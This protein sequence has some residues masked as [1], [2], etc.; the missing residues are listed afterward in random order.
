[1]GNN[2]YIGIDLG[3]S[4]CRVIAIDDQQNIIAVQ[5]HAL[6]DALSPEQD[7]HAHWEIVL[8]VLTH[9]IF[10]CQGFIIKALAVDATSGSILVTDKLGVPVSPILMYHDAR[11]VEQSN[12][13]THSAP[14]QSGAHGANSGLAKLL[15]L[16]QQ[17]DLPTDIKLLHQADW[18]NVN[19]G[20]PV[21]I[22]D[23]NN[24][25]KSGY[26]PVE[27]Q[28]PHWIDNLIK[29]S[30]LPKVVPPGTVIGRLSAQL[31]SQFELENR[32]DIV[33]G[34]TD[35]IA[36]LMATGANEIGD[37]VTSLGSTLVVKLISRHPLFRPEQGIYSHR[38]GDKWLVGGAS[39]SG[40][41]VLKH[42]FNDQQLQQLSEQISVDD[43]IE[44]YYPLLTPG[45]RFPINDPQLQPRLNPR[46]LS[47]VKFL[48]GILKGIANIE[49]QA[50][51]CL[52]QAGA[53]PLASIRTSGGGA[54]N[55]V[56]QTIRQ[57]LLPVPLITAKHTEAA[58][59][60]A[61]LAQGTH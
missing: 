56:W 1:M 53:S 50:Y 60:A 41:A 61:L 33:A 58:Y 49:K 3:T 54:C 48:H 36:A 2:A 40:G 37:A 45:E 9:V 13:I 34:T 31:C 32:P 27:R 28:W 44:D 38:L 11:A 24:A 19:L 14:A 8:Q 51:Q 25:L 30:I 7:P 57:Q 22:T 10:Q 35:S 12:K 59:G 42:Y 6:T 26:D 20:A 55:H 16:Q 43:S 5:Q 46:P 29:R 52:Q 39:N 47:D 21:G 17:K 23:E 15:Y 4:G 18:I